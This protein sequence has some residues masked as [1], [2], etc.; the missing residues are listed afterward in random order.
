MTEHK[1]RMLSQALSVLTNECEAYEGEP[2]VKLNNFVVVGSAVNSTL[3]F[4][5]C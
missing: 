1:R 5:D 3:K 2:T 4:D